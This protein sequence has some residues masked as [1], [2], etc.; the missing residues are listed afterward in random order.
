MLESAA[1]CCIG[2]GSF[3]SNLR[4]EVCEFSVAFRQ[5]IRL[6]RSSLPPE[7]SL[8]VILRRFAN[9]GSTPMVPELQFVSTE[10]FT[11]H[12]CARIVPRFPLTGITKE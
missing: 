3:G 12:L 1:V 6:F 9:P 4:A 8:H 5:F 10:G 2:G 7:F 11:P